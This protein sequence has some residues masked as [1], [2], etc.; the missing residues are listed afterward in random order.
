MFGE[1]TWHFM[2]FPEIYW[3]H[4]EMFKSCRGHTPTVNIT[5]NPS[6]RL[7]Y[8]ATTYSSHCERRRQSLTANSK[9][10]SASSIQG[11]LRENHK[12]AK[13]L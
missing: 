5:A 12:A 2:K 3:S 7:L 6:V 13:W 11:G 1:K 4:T 10:I 9:R 8:G